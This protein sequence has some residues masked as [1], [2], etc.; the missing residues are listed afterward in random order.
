MA[1]QG[2]SRRKLALS[3]GLSQNALRRWCDGT[4]HSYDLDALVAVFRHAGLSMDELFGLVAAE[5]SPAGSDAARVS[6]LERRLIRYEWILDRLRLAEQGAEVEALR[7][8]LP[9]TAQVV[10]HATDLAQSTA[11]RLM[12]APESRRQPDRRI[13]GG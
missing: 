8:S 3:V 12:P 9:K 2:W 4:N 7:A 1:K 5:P 6:E 11:E 13:S 10:A